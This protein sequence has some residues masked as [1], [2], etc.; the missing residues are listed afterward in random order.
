MREIIKCPKCDGARIYELSCDP[1]IIAPH[2]HEINPA[3]CYEPESDDGYPEM[4]P[5]W[6]CDE[7]KFAWIPEG[8]CQVNY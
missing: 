6:V 1:D 3:A 8:N 2:V 4:V 5:Q 7:C